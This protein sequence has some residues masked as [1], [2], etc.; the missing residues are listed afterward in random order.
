VEQVLRRQLGL[1][2]T[3]IKRAK[4]QPDGILLDG[5]RVFS[6]ATVRA[7]QR[8]TLHLPEQSDS[9][10]EPTPGPVD[11]CYEDEWLLVVNKPAGL[12]VHPGPGH[13]A[14]TLGNRLTWLY[15]QR[16]EQLVLRSV[17][18]LD[19]GTS[20][21]LVVA[22]RAETHEALQQLLH[23][24]HFCRDYVAL[25]DR[26]P[27]PEAGTIDRPIDR[28]PGALNQYRVSPDGK[29]AVTAYETLSCRD[30]MALVGLR[31]FTGR[32]HQIRVHMADLGCPLLGDVVYGG[33]DSFPRPALHSYR[34]ALDHPF[35]GAHLVWTAP[36]PEDFRA[37]G[38]EEPQ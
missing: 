15:R 34:L 2:V 18:R 29:R 36:L 21:L 12:V 9:D 37:L 35:T 22:K 33:P 38:W 3:R 8:L 17:N 19:K 14:D 6:N 25:T 31:L 16:G 20:G 1:S 27:Q 4:F 24:Q 5:Q 10:L 23:T 7:G 32:T 11:I 26:C 28:V 13:Y 30:G